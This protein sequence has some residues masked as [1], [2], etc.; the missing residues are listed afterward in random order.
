MSLAL[1]KKEKYTYGDYLKWPDNIKCEIINGVVYDMAPA[2]LRKHQA[3]A[4]DILVQ[5]AGFLKDKSCRVYAAPFD[6]RLPNKG[7]KN[8]QI[9]TVV[10]PDISVIC[11]R[12]K[13]DERGCVGAPDLIIEI[14]SSGTASKDLKEKFALY[15]RHGVK[16]YWIVQP[17]EKMIMVFIRGKNNEY[18]K[19]RVYSSEDTI[20]S[21]KVKG[22]SV[23]LNDLAW[24]ED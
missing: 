11:D 12:K 1:K 23:D 19:P 7:V 2:P 5:I 14:V 20:I 16:E 24:E 13:L 3:I 8:D 18:G 21:K 17:E 4:R 6:V 15:E 10:Q 9:D 22:I